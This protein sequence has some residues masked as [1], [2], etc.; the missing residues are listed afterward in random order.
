MET[1]KLKEKNTLKAKLPDIEKTLTMVE[2]LKERQVGDLCLPWAAEVTL[3]CCRKAG[4]SRSRIS[5]FATTST[6]R[7]TCQAVTLFACGSG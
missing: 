5:I 3:V 2:F 7:Q 4:R 6:P 1:H